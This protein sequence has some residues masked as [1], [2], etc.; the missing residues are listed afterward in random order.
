VC[1]G[2]VQGVFRR[3][4]EVLGSV[5]GVFCVRTSV[6]P[7]PEVTPKLELRLFGMRRKHVLSQSSVTGMKRALGNVPKALGNLSVSIVGRGLH[8]STFRLNVS[9]VC[10]IGGAFRCCL[11]GERGVSGGIRGCLG[12]ISCQKRLRLS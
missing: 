4:Y 2:V 12:Y 10:G 6:S 9:A 7:C 11:R 5:E 8:S 3:C 1:S